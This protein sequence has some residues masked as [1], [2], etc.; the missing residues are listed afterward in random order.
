MSDHQ[1]RTSTTPGCQPLPPART[2]YID[3]LRVLLTAIVITF[4]VFLFAGAN[5]SPD[6]SGGLAWPM[7][8]QQHWPQDAALMIVAPMFQVSGLV[9][10]LAP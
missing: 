10:Q 4:H 3:W 2:Y 6:A 8:R 7:V 1:P 9:R 5:A